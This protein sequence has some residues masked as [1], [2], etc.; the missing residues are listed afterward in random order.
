MQARYVILRVLLEAGGGIVA[1]ERVTGSDGKPDIIVKLDRSL[2]ES[3]GKAAIRDFLV[4]L[5]VM[6]VS[7]YH[8][9]VF[10]FLWREIELRCNWLQAEPFCA[11][12]LWKCYFSSFFIVCEFKIL[13]SIT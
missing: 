12:A 3:R 11:N 10:I 9:A 1:V 5:Q 2:I 8:H 13:V 7:E 4:K 6:R